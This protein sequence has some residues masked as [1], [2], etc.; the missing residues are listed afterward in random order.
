MHQ[1]MLLQTKGSRWLRLVAVLLAIAMGTAAA[2]ASAGLALATPDL[3]PKTTHDVQGRENC[4][5]CHPVGSGGVKPSPSSHASYTN[6]TCLGCHPAGVAAAAQP[7]A[8]PTAKPEQPAAEATAEPS[9]PVA[10][11]TCRGKDG[12]NRRPRHGRTRSGGGSSGAQAHHPPSRGQ[13]EL[14]DVPSG[15]G[16][17]KR[18]AGRP[19]RPHRR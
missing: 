18:P 7:A 16:R 4:L 13:R 1:K 19:L 17:S 5:T 11:P 2:I 8:E 12:A 3:Q 10:E 15:G 14:H 9:Q 6:A